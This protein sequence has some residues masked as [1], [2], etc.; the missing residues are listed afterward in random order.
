MAREMEQVALLLYIQSIISMVIHF[1]FARN[2]V[3][4]ITGRQYD[5]RFK[6][7]LVDHVVQFSL[8][9]L[10]GAGEGDVP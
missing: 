6:D 3:M 8:S 2:P 9:G 7:E 5:D 4:R 10:N 1:N